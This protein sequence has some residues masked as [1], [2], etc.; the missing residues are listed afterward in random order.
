MR[1]IILFFIFFQEFRAQCVLSVFDMGGGYADSSSRVFNLRY[2][3]KAS[4]PLSAHKKK[5]ERDIII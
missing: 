2:P 1:S 4:L 5:V 3:R